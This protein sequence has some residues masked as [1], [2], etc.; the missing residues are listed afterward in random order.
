MSTLN[1]LGFGRSICSGA[2]LRKT[3]AQIKSSP[4]PIEELFAFQRPLA[5]EDEQ[6]CY[7]VPL[8]NAGTSWHTASV[9]SCD[10]VGPLRTAAWVQEVPLAPDDKHPH[11]PAQCPSA[12]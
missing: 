8:H 4:R 7:D 3:S 5:P 2:G 12:P 6:S 1:G 9:S 11:R 10:D